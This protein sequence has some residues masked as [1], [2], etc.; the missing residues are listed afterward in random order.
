MRSAPASRAFAE[1]GAA[2]ER[3]GRRG[4]DD[5]PVAGLQRDCPRFADRAALEDDGASFRRNR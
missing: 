2:N 1:K 3:G 5:G 4:R